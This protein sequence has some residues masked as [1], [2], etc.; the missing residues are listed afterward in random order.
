MNV[1]V[2]LETKIQF[3]NMWCFVKRRGPNLR[4]CSVPALLWVI[5]MRRNIKDL[6]DY[7]GGG[8]EELWDNVRFGHHFGHL[9]LET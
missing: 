8:V 7:S 2:L 3:L 1:S 4:R 6:S 5:W 9:Y